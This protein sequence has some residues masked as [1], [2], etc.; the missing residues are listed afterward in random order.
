[1]QLPLPHRAISGSLSP[2][3]K[4]TAG[5]LH[6]AVFSLLLPFPTP[7]GLL[8]QSYC[9]CLRLQLLPHA[10]PPMG[11]AALLLVVITAKLA[12]HL[13]CTWISPT[14]CKR[15]AQGATVGRVAVLLY[16][17]RRTEELQAAT[18]C[19][20]RRARCRTGGGQQIRPLSPPPSRSEVAARQIAEPQRRFSASPPRPSPS[21]TSSSTPSLCGGGGDLW[22]IEQGWPLSQSPTSPSPAPRLELR[23]P[24]S[25]GRCGAP[26]G[27]RGSE[28]GATARS[29]RRLLGAAGSSATT[30]GSLAPRRLP[31]AATD[32]LAH[33]SQLPE[34][35]REGD[36]RA[37]GVPIIYQHRYCLSP[38]A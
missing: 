30:A 27:R 16:A 10:S 1:M 15:R 34:H 9:L 7:T 28:T 21:L 14:S 37:A 33:G 24:C 11:R 36:V 25:S 3:S 17:H 13:R 22:Q 12:C 8:L 26:P 20:R 23:L 2:S 38:A 6:P 29:S 18:P 32:P 19:G 4:Q 35:M 5:S 31:R